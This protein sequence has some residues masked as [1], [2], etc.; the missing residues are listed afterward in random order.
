[1]NNIHVTQRLAL[2]S[3]LKFYYSISRFSRDYI[4]K[5]PHATL[6]TATTAASA[7]TATDTA[8]RQK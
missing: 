5:F 1:M 8:A 3:P 7:A 6:S 2:K 4:M